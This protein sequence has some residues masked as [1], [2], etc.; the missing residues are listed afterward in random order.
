LYSK[1]KC[2]HSI[3]HK[4]KLLDKIICLKRQLAGPTLLQSQFSI[5]CFI[6]IKVNILEFDTCPLSVKFISETIRVRGNLVN[7][8]LSFHFNQLKKKM[9]QN[10]MKYKN[11]IYLPNQSHFQHS[12]CN[13]AARFLK[14]EISLC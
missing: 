4:S 14:K 8:K 11:S 13:I 2:G 10:W 12:I 3:L 1:S 7:R 5:L 9:H 6:N